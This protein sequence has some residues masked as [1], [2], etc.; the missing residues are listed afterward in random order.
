MFT[1]T[2]IPWVAF[3]V[4]SSIWIIGI[5]AKFIVQAIKHPN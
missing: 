4:F 2:S 3:G 5:T 1:K